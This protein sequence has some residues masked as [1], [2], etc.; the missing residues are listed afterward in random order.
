MRLT[1]KHDDV[2]KAMKKNMK[3]DEEDD[4]EDDPWVQRR[5]R[6]LLPHEFGSIT[7]LLALHRLQRLHV[8]R[9]HE[10]RCTFLLPPRADRS[11]RRHRTEDV[12]NGLSKLLRL[13]LHFVPPL[14]RL[15]AL[16]SACPS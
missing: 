14:E 5:Q 10:S 9:Y 16:M 11:A 6:K 7:T 13:D 8:L 3:E 2:K 15:L 1:S 4:D 12:G